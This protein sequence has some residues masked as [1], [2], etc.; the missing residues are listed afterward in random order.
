MFFSENEKE[1]ILRVK[2]AINE[3]K[4]G[5]MVILTDDE[6][7]EN[8][9]DLV[10]AAEKVTPEAVNFMAKYGRGL[11]CLTLM[12]ERIEQLGL[13]MMVEDN[14]SRFNT[15][16]TV[17]IE[18]RKGVSTGIS[19]ADRAKTIKTAVAKDAT[20]DDLISPGH[21]FPLKAQRGG[22][23]VRV[24]QT[25][26]S[27]D[28]AR[29]AGLFPAGVICEVMNEDGTMA[30]RD[31]LEKFCLEHKLT[32]LSVN[33]LIIYRLNHESLVKEK[34]HR[35]FPFEISGESVEMDVSIF[36][37]PVSEREL[38]AIS[39]G[40]INEEEPILVRM[41]RG[42]H[43]SDLFQIGRCNCGQ[44]LQRSLEMIKEAGKGIIVYIDDGTFSLSECMNTHIIEPQD[45]DVLNTKKHNFGLGAQVLKELGVGKLKLITEHQYELAGIKAYGLEIVDRVS[46]VK[47]AVT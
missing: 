37:S 21:V 29:L 44:V 20:P 40:K 13:K 3:I 22:V 33:D 46:P 7:R 36:T 4:A 12:P 14:S 24:G 47:G 25:E 31:D 27:V 32:M 35:K 9:G 2:K 8:E 45:E 17:S 39:L 5:R 30:R 16:F 1:A 34:I 41:H 42:C 23:L 28:L 26:G 19:A 43:I 38:M 6:D 15:A 18:A 11:I 10:L